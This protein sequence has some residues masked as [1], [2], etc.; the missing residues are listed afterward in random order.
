MEAIEVVL[1]MDT[2]SQ[3]GGQGQYLLATDQSARNFEFTVLQ[4]KGMLVA[5]CLGTLV[6]GEVVTGVAVIKINI[7]VQTGGHIFQFCWRISDRIET[8]DD[9]AHARTADV[10]R[11]DPIFFQH[12]EYANMSKAFCASARQGQAQ[13][14]WCRALSKKWSEEGQ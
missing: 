8:A 12:L 1:V 3:P 2:G 5:I 9:T 10:I 4:S 7:P 6:N 13:A 11:E 14:G